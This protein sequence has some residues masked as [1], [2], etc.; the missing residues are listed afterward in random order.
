MPHSGSIPSCGV[1]LCSCIDSQR[2]V[3]GRQAPF[4][5]YSPNP[6]YDERAGTFREDRRTPL[7]ELK[8]GEPN[9]IVPA[10]DF[11]GEGVVWDQED[12]CIYWTDINRF[13]VHRY[14]LKDKTHQTWFFAEPVT[15]VLLTSR[16]DTLALS[17][18]SGIVL[19]KPDTDAPPTPLFSLPGWPQVR[20]N[21]AAV[22]PGGAL[23]V[24]SMRNNV[25]KSGK[26]GEAG[27]RD[28]VLYRLDGTGKSLEWRRDLGISNTL[29]WSPDRTIFYFADTLQ[30]RIWAYDYNLTRKSIAG[31]RTFF[32]GFER[33][34]PDGSAI[35][36]DGFIWNCRYGG[37]CIVRVAP[38]GKVDRVIEMPVNRP[39]NC[40]F[41]GEDGKTLYITCASPAPGEWEQFGG[42]LFALETNVTGVAENKFQL[43]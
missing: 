13:L 30:N 3:S 2:F 12:R 11:C 10:G 7:P 27:G 4:L 39:T 37:S 34:S 22:D 6:A 14:V 40:T 41:G 29:V 42:G 8:I 9:C 35:D 36:T 23:W 17:L 31:E 33:G 16:K 1:D 19:W 21:D 15:A 5:V 26:P 20:C 24:G 43:A 32:D 28:G 18:G 25:L 38:D